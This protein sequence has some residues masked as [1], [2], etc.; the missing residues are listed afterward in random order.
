VD[1]PVFNYIILPILITFARIVDVSLSTLRIILISRGN[2]VVAPFLGFF[3]QLIWVMAIGSIM[4]NL[5]NPVTYL[6]FS[7][8][9]AIGNYV[10]VVI[11]E[12]LAMGTM[13]V[14]VITKKKAGD[15]I[16]ILRARKYAVT[17]MHAWGN[18][19]EVSIIY[20]VVSRKKLDPLIK[21]IK[22]YHPR[23]FFSIEDIRFVSEDMTP[24]ASATL[25]KRRMVLARV[26]S[27]NKR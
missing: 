16:R 13:I 25:Q 26:F 9:F 19:G 12:R 1:F 21:A 10:G 2:K 6:A 5:D 17:N 8:G 15:L 27:R 4:T 14:Q 22:K 3:E 20:I 7:L 18:S 23:A 11:E 24:R